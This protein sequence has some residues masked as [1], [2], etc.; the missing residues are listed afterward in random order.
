MGLT[1]NERMNKVW[2]KCQLAKDIEM[3]KRNLKQLK[4]DRAESG[5]KGFVM[6]NYIFEDALKEELKGKQGVLDLLYKKRRSR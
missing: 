2:E 6:D 4:K 3:I 5:D 1:Y